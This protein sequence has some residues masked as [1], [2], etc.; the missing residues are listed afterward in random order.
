M[1][2]INNDIFEIFKELD[3]FGMVGQNA[4]MQ[5]IGL[6]NDNVAH[7]RE[8]ARRGVLGAVSPS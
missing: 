1:L 2:F 5:H 7:G 8:F 6:V 3:P 4:R